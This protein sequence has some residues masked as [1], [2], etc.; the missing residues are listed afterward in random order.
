MTLSL[1]IAGASRKLAGRLVLKDISLQLE[2]GRFLVL[3]GESGSGKT[4][5]L[6]MAAGLDRTDTGTIRIQGKL[7]DDSKAVFIATEKRRLGMVFQEFA[8]WPHLSCLENVALAA[9]SDT[10]NRNK[11]AMALLDRLGVAA[12]AQRRPALL[13]GGQQQR[14]GIAR[15][16]AAKPYLLLLDEPLSS[17]DMET[18]DRLRE[19]LM[20]TVR[21]AGISALLV[22]HD[23]EDCWHMADHVAVLEHGVIRQQGAPRDL[24]RQPASAYV[25]RFTGAAGGMSVPVMA[26]PAGT[27]LDIGGTLVPLAQRIATPRARLFWREGGVCRAANGTGIP[28]QAIS[29]HF[30][31]GRFRVRWQVAGLSRPLVSFEPEIV[32]MGP[33]H[34]VINPDKLFLFPETGDKHP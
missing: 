4:T 34:I 22:S 27:I 31:A 19:E 24:W 28:A 23:P 33:G 12:F 21:D 11:V 16:L 5:L 17:L 25:A 14:V 20:E 2:P 13:S 26:S 3:A 6:R 8:L 15:A 30:D 18:R 9:P 10:A 29:V 1:D 7:V 32:P